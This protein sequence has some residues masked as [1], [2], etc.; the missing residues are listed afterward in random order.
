[1]FCVYENVTE[2]TTVSAAKECFSI[3]QFEV[4]K[5]ILCI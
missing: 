2:S 3:D 1:M 5:A 4:Y